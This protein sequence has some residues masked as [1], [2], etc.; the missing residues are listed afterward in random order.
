MSKKNLNEIRSL[1]GGYWRYDILDFHYLVNLHFPTKEMYDKIKQKLPDLIECYPSTQKVIANL[2]AKWK[3]KKY[4]TKENLIIVNGSSEAIKILNQIITKITVPIPC[5]NEYVELPENKVNLLP[6]SEKN[7]FKIDIDELIKEVKESNSE[8]TVIN[9]PNNPTGNVVSRKDIIKLLETGTKVII[10]EAF[11]DFSIED[12]VEDLVEEYNNLIIV[13]TVTK[14][15]G[16]AGLRLGYILT[17]ND[18][19]KDKVKKLLPIWNINSISE[20]FIEIFPE[21]EKD[22]WNSIGKTKKE[23]QK[24]FEELRNIPFLEPY[25]TK[26]NFIFCKTQISSKK[27]AKHLYDAH[28]IIIRSE[29]NQKELQ[30]DN[31]IRI[32]IRGKND[33]D[34]LISALNE[35][36]Q[37]N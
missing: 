12:S 2:L 6:L 27:I 32:A 3:N 8:F 25:E 9:N 18:D 22:Y 28:N 14:T 10:D 5:F 20:Y 33:N 34:K 21:F 11:I 16:L 31:Y 24:L 15:M 19:I 7:K 4:F 29:L 17:K 30:S 23:R 35:L 13:K 1:H 37:I 36:N 26:S